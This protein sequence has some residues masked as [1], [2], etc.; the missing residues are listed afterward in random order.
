M[1]VLINNNILSK[2]WK[3]YQIMHLNRR[4]A[5]IREDG[6]CTIYYPS[7]MPFNLYLEPTA[8]TDIETRVN[9]LTNFYYWCSS[10]VLT[11]DRKYAKEILASIGAAQA[12]TDKERAKVALSYHCLSLTDVYW[13]RTDGEN[14]KFESICLYNHSL[15]D[16]FV[17]VSLFG[18]QLTA[19]NS[20]LIP[21]EEAACD[22]GT[23][24]VAPKAWVRENGEFFLLKD[25][26]MKDV[27][28][29]LLASR[30][31]DCFNVP[32]VSYSKSVFEGKTVSKSKIITNTDYSIVPMEFIEVYCTNNDINRDVLI[33]EK[34]NYDFCMMNIVDYLIG[35][36]DRHW[37]NWGF[38]IDNRSNRMMGLYPLM[39]F[40]KAFC[41][42][43][44]V[45]GGKC[46]TV[47]AQLSQK[48]AALDAV[49][50]VG[51]NMIAD[52]DP[53][54]FD[55][56]E[57]YQMFLKRLSILKSIDEYSESVE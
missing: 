44:D 51:L 35:N 24:G 52:A 28:A 5:S 30:I 10:R 13:V 43:S 2:G 17:E 46:Q 12:V 32:H 26:D 57:T 29:E 4:V 49:K 39:D 47:S 22:V 21:L 33:R 16:A 15:S 56:S 9:N 14:L 53:L 40:N 34:A 1:S 50:S 8:D 27:E 37:G 55:Q 38:L 11:L 7:F 19:Q 20:E 36:T 45:E 54:W 6:T 48:E 18:K 42:Y 31:V 41:N 23:S 25:G 3:R